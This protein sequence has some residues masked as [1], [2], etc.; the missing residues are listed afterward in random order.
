MSILRW[1]LGIAVCA[2]LGQYLLAMLVPNLAMEVIYREGA[3]H[4]GYNRM[5]VRP[6]PDATARS[7]VRPSPDLLYASC[8][9]N[10]Q[11][12]PL[13]IEA[14]VPERYW[15]MQFYQMN[16]DNFAGITNQR[17]QQSRVGSLAKVTLIGASDDPAKYR[18][19]VIQSPTDRG[20]ILLRASAIGDRAPQQAALEASRC[21]SG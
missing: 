5:V 16:T 1:L 13:I 14:P 12:G 6:I 15:S 17:D 4:G 9:Y 8:L 7:I 18:G 19:E 11:D 3:D 21:E 2:W 20:I 10:L